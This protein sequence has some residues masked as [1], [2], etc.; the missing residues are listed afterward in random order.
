M[1]L[2][3]QIDFSE[4]HTNDELLPAGEYTAIIVAS[5]AKP[6]D[7]QTQ[8]GYVI[9]KSGKGA[10]LPMTFEVCEGEFKGR[11]I[12]KNFNLQNQNAD[13]V[14]IARG[15]IK[16]LLQALNWD[17][18]KAPGG[19]SDT[20]ELHMIPMR[21]YVAQVENHQRGELQNEIKR[22]VVAG[23]QASGQPSLAAPI[24]TAPMTKPWLRRT[25][26]ATVAP[27]QAQPVSQ[28]QAE[29]SAQK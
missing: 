23:S 16:Q 24:G 14:R 29:E 15:E 4:V 10:Y 3:G 1:A 19:P 2:L 6:T 9:S 11:Q 12:R 5:G 8:E 25:P 17:F 28:P 27:P 22:F 7:Q 26:S 13:A 21:I 20:T 18:A